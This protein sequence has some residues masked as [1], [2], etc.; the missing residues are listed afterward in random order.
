MVTYEGPNIM[1]LTER[2]QA[3]AVIRDM[4]AALNETRNKRLQG[5]Q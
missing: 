5:Q 1:V 4:V 2:S 3:E